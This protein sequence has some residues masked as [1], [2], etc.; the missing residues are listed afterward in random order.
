MKTLFVGGPKDGKREF[1][2]TGYGDSIRVYSHHTAYGISADTF[3]RDDA[4]V[5]MNIHT[6]ELKR[7][8]DE[9]GNDYAV[10]FHSSVKNSMEAL[11]KGYRY[12][13]SPRKR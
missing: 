9:N 3:D 5:G 1:F 2:P 7:F 11:I 12:H 6:Y 8:R 10:A 4:L 13:R